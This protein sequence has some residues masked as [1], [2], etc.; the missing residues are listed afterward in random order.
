M[1]LVLVHSPLVGPTPPTGSAAWTFD[2][3]AGWC[4]TAASF[5]LLSE[6]YRADFERARARGWA[7]IER[8]GGHLDIV[9]DAD[10]IAGTIIELA[11]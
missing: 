7:T 2:V 3:P 9:N 6:A 8:L 10:A 5:L 4:D 1:N 11:G